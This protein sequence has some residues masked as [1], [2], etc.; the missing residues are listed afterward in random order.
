MLK[1]ADSADCVYRSLHFFIFAA[2]TLD[3]SSVPKYY[4]SDVYN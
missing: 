4:I 2:K 3:N 1:L